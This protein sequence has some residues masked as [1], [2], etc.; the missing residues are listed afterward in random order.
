MQLNDAIKGAIDAR[1]RLA[2][3]EAVVSPVIMSEQMYR[4]GQYTAEIESHLGDLEQEYEI[5]FAQSYSEYSKELSA[6]AAKQKA[7]VDLAELK[8]NIK[9]LSR[10]VSANWKAHTGIM[11]RINHLDRESRGAV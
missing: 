10:Y 11:A 2:T 6:T 3:R 5:K 8:G 1:T 9:R 4:L 7:D